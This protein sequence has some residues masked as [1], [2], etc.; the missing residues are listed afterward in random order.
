[1]ETLHIVVKHEVGL[2]ARPAAKFVETASG[3]DSE[4]SVKNLT[5]DKGPVNAKSILSILTLG[6]QQNC[7]IEIEADGVDEKE[8]VDALKALIEDNFGE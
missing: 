2:H 1:M 8:A 3:F 6:V 4:I 7:E 5:E